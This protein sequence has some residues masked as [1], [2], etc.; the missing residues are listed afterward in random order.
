MVTELRSFLGFTNY[1]RCFI[2]VYAKVAYPLYD[3]ISSNNAAHKKQNIQSMDECQKAFDT[4]KVSVHLC[5]ILAFADFT[6]LF[7]LHTGASTIGLGAILY[8]E[9]ERKDRV[10]TYVSRALS[11]SKSHYL[12]HKLEI[13]ALKWAVT[14][15]FQE[16]LYGNTF[17][18]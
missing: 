13:L 6:K 17:A 11:K 2:K 3:Q 16:Y 12:A 14:E 8:Q 4:L 18:S 7:K 1:Y 5:P 10:I 9:Q 15:S